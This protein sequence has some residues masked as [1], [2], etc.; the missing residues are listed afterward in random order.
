MYGRGG[1]IILEDAQS[2]RN[3][4]SRRAR[5]VLDLKVTKRD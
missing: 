5:N 4:A 3:A 2:V 1:T